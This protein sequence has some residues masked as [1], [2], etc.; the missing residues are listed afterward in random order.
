MHCT[1]ISSS[2]FSGLEKRY[3]PYRLD[4]LGKVAILEAINKYIFIYL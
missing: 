4:N 3:G 2:K 1:S